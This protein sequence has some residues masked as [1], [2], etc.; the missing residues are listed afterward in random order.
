M[1]VSSYL[2][3]PS[4]CSNLACQAE[5]YKYH[6][7]IESLATV[8][9]YN[10]RLNFSKSLDLVHSAVV[11]QRLSQT[12]SITHTL[13][14][15]SLKQFYVRLVNV[16]RNLRV[17]SMKCRIKT[18]GKHFMRTCRFFFVNNIFQPSM[19]ENLRDTNNK[20]H[21]YS[22]IKNDYRYE[23]YLNI[24]HNCL[25]TFIRFHLSL[26]WLPIERGRCSKPKIPR[27]DRT[28]TFC[29]SNEIGNEIH[30]LLVCE[31]V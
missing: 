19:N 27:D 5:L 6:L 31:G 10:E 25:T 22:L 9:R 15:T 11:S 1:C 26:H 20:L 24:T 8:I 30:C 17:S 2:K 7:F 23:E 3:M 12:N 4:R 21:L 13:S 29:D 18:V 16:P 14:P 28:C